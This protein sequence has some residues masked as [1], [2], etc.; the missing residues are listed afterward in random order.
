M[1]AKKTKEI[2]IGQVKR[3]AP[4]LL[5]FGG[6]DAEY[7][8][9]VTKFKLLGVHISDDMKWARHVDVLASKVASRIYFLKQLKRSA[10]LLKT[11]FVFCL[12][13]STNTGIRLPL[14]HSN[15]TTGQSDLLESLQKRAL[16]IIS[17]DNDYYVSH[18]V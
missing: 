4:P 18:P 8:E 14:W 2:F 7:V 17:N 1:N 3:N 12:S 10:H 9:G 13:H 11:R 16:K 15:L 6:T 5:T